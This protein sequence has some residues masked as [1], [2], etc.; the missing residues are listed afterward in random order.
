MVSEILVNSP[1][2][3][4]FGVCGEAPGC[5]PQSVK[6]V[7]SNSL[8]GCFQRGLLKGRRATLNVGG[9]IPKTV[10]NG[11][12]VDKGG[13]LRV[14][15]SLLLPGHHDVSISALLHHPHQDGLK[16]LNL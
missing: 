9:T 4:W 7:P 16:P 14:K 8:G 3:Y 5:F 13:S 2:L 1:Q 15:N 6:Q 12:S 10:M 11:K